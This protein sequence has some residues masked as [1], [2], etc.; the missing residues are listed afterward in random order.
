M[1]AKELTFALV[2]K[3]ERRVRELLET[4]ELAFS[5]ACKSAELTANAG[6]GVSSASQRE[7]DHLKTKKL[8][9]A[10]V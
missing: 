2:Q 9:F 1:K 4:L 7:H 6:V 3:S 10:L 5:P 8:G